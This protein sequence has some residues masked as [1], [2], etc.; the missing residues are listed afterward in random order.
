MAIALHPGFEL[1]YQPEVVRLYLSLLTESR[2]FNTLE[3]AAGALQ[4][5]S[6]GNWMV[7]GQVWQGGQVLRE[8]I[9]GTSLVQLLPRL[10]G[11][12]GP[13]SPPQDPRSAWAAGTACTL[14]GGK[15]S[16]EVP[17]SFWG[18]ALS[19]TGAGRFSWREQSGSGGG[20]VLEV[21]G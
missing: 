2:N 5:L 4:N 1:L 8:G 11:K 7:R 18:R 10:A 3:A 14:D 17:L 20:R 21:Y 15:A 9:P 12:G 19:G 16:V 6:A 13:T